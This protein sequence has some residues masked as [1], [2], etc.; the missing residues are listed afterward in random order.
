M[1]AESVVVWTT[2]GE[3]LATI[4]LTNVPDVRTLKRHLQKLHGQPRFRQR[5][6]HNGSV[7]QD[8][9]RVHELHTPRDLQM[10]LLPY[11]PASPSTRTQ[12]LIAC[13]TGN[14]ADVETLLQLPLDP[15]DWPYPPLI[16]VILHPRS[17]EVFGLLLEAGADKNVNHN[18]WTPVRAALCRDMKM[19]LQLK[20]LDSLVAL[21]EIDTLAAV[22]L[23]ISCLSDIAMEFLE[24]QWPH[25][26]PDSAAP[27]SRCL[28]PLLVA[29]LTKLSVEF[30][31]WF[32]PFRMVE[33]IA[34]GVAV[35]ADSVTKSRQPGNGVAMAV[36]KAFIDDNISFH[37]Q[38]PWRRMLGI[39]AWT[40]ARFRRLSYGVP[41][42]F[43]EC[44]HYAPVLFCNPF[45]QAV[46]RKLVALFVDRARAR[47]TSWAVGDSC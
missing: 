8:S 4:P 39:L 7:L 46:F 9:D 37:H 15:N 44:L 3:K 2:A 16:Q 17:R 25:E 27:S 1:T 47:L 41:Y 21:W 26:S 40:I 31:F 35:A 32:I 5:L 10:V 23:W 14:H 45:L 38:M 13:A 28:F 11:A 36:R 6:V 12:F 34:R 19:F 20:G 29:E 24:C 43:R 42:T 30:P 33:L 18:G 22:C